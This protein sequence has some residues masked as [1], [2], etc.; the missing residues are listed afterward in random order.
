MFPFPLQ[1]SRH[2]KESDGIQDSNQRLY[3]PRTQ[4]VYGSQSYTSKAT[5]SNFSSE[6]KGGIGVKTREGGGIRKPRRGWESTF[7]CIQWATNWTCDTTR[8]PTL[9]EQQA[10]APKSHQLQHK[11]NLPV[12]LRTGSAVGGT[13]RVGINRLVDF[14]FFFFLFCNFLLLKTFPKKCVFSFMSG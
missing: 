1:L 10:P 11:G 5:V 9:E 3:F 14:V 12:H 6:P 4:I 8:G 7:P 13:Q 2:S